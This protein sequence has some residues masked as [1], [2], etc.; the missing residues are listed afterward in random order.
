MAHTHC[1]NPRRIIVYASDWQTPS[2]GIR[3]LYRHVD[4][5]SAHGYPAF[6]AH[7]K[8]GFRCAWFANTTPIVYPPDSYPSPQ[9]IIVLPEIHSWDLTAQSPG[10]PKVIFNQNAYQTFAFQ[11]PQRKPN[12]APYQQEDVFATIVVSEDSREYLNFA[13]PEHPV[14]RIRNSIDAS[15]FHFEL[16]KKRQIAVM[17]RKN[18]SDTN[19]VL[20]ILECRGALKGFQVVRIED[21]TEAETA[22]I[23]CDSQILLSVASEE[24]WSLPPMEAMACGCVTIGYDGRGGREYF[25]TEHGFPIARSDIV[26]FAMTVERVIAELDRNPRSMIEMTRRAS[27]FVLGTYTPGREEQDILDA[28]RQILP[29]LH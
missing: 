25:T 7:Q 6:I 17:P 15:L 5:L 1:V 26:G 12:L 21:K 16:N 28:W 4:V 3:K 13:F 29:L 19:Q 20:S 10:I 24:G 14:F 9:D 8:P 11:T 18:P 23:L 22:A 2:G 27:E